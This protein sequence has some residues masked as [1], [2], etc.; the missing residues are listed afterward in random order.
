MVGVLEIGESP[1]SALRAWR[2]NFKI[3][4]RLAFELFEHTVG[5]AEL[6]VVDSELVLNPGVEIAK[7]SLVGILEMSTALDA[8]SSSSG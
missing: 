1:K 5:V 4:R 6:V 2:R 8:T 3:L 7:R